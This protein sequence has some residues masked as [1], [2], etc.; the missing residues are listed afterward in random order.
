MLGLTTWIV[1]GFVFAHED[2]CDSFRQLSEYSV[3]S[4]YVVP[5]ACVG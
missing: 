4:V 5:Y 1:N 3:C 2:K